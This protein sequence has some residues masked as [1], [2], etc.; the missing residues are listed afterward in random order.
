MFLNQEIIKKKSLDSIVPSIFLNKNK[1]KW[2]SAKSA[3]PAVLWRLVFSNF[4]K[5]RFVLKHECTCMLDFC[6]KHDRISNH[7]KTHVT[8]VTTKHKIRKSSLYI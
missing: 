8:N 3:Y 4:Y 1:S 6:L 7:E 2:L 5:Y